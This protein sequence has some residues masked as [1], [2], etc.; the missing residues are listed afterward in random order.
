MPTGEGD[1]HLTST[2]GVRFEFRGE[3]GEVYNLIACHN[4]ALRCVVAN[5]SDGHPGQVIRRL[6][7]HLPNGVNIDIGA[8]FI[9]IDT[10]DHKIVVKQDGGHITDVGEVRPDPL[11]GDFPHL[12][13]G[14]T[15]KIPMDREHTSGLL[16]DGDSHAFPA[17]EAKY[18]TGQFWSFDG[19][20]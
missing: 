15:P 10:P 12:D 2:S 9:A 7:V 6:V 16:Y 19:D 20:Y 17:D 1:P 14:F 3:P 11:R 5:F 18:R 4:L 13:F 8:T